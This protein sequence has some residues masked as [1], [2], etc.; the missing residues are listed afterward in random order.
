MR[1]L[2]FHFVTTLLIFFALI[3]NDAALSAQTNRQPRPQSSDNLQ[4]APDIHFTVSMPQPHTHL[5]EVEM[6][7]RWNTSAPAQADLVMPVWTPG[8][9]LV[10]EY[11]RHVQDF[12]AKDEAANSSVAQGQQEHVAD[13]DRRRDRGRDNGA[14]GISRPTAFT[15]TN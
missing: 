1:L 4:S 3:T 10:R 15:R 7:V 12:A 14:R 8:S 6:R 11:A 5:L 13:Y 9:Y 2:R